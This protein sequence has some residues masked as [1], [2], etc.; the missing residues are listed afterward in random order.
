MISQRPFAL[1][2]GAVVVTFLF[3]SVAIALEAMQHWDAY[4][5]SA[6]GITGDIDLSSSRIVFQ[7]GTVLELSYI[8]SAAGIIQVQKDLPARIYRIVNPQD[9]ILLHGNPLCDQRPYY[10]A[11]IESSMKPLMEEWNLL[12]LIFIKGREPPNA[13]MEQDRNCGG[14]AFTRV[15]GKH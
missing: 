11:W 7:N 8:G 15:V 2:A 14:Y 12:E 4:S 5:T 9:P 13:N 3:G 1:L 6:E 10:L